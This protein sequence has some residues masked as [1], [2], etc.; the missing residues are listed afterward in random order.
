MATA[1]SRVGA[2]E[3]PPVSRFV[4]AIALA[5]CESEAQGAADGP[6]LDVDASDLGVA[7]V[8]TT[9]PGRFVMLDASDERIGTAAFD[10]A[11]TTVR[12]TVHLGEHGGTLRFD[13]DTFDARCDADA[14][15]CE[16]A[17]DLAHR[18]G[19]AVGVLPD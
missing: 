4:L 3:E 11:A 7:Q 12:L 17:L 8:R 16:D 10:L 5:A 9:A 14:T 6:V 1:C 15:S 13:G 19:T 18:I 2:L